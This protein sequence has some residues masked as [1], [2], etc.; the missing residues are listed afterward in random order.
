MLKELDNWTIDTDARLEALC[1]RIDGFWSQFASHAV[2]LGE[3]ERQ[4]HQH[5]RHE[6]PTPNEKSI[7]RWVHELHERVVKLEGSPTPRPNDEVRV[8]TVTQIER[9]ERIERAAREIVS[10]LDAARTT[11]SAD[12]YAA[13]ISGQFDRLVIAGLRKDL[14]P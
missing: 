9:W 7:V 11:A 5:S 8:V 10:H 12:S 3:L 1:K 2:R 13:V 4:A 14:K 6:E